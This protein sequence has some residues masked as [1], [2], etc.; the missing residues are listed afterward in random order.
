MKEQVSHTFKWPASKYPPK[1][2]ISFVINEVTI[3]IEVRLET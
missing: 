1:V 3:D 2:F